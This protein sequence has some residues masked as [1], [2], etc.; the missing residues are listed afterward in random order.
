MKG[1]QGLIPLVIVLALAFGIS[2]TQ[3]ALG[4]GVFLA[5]AAE[6]SINV[7]FV[8]VIVFVLACIMAFSTGTSWGT[9][10]IM[11][12]I[13]I[14]MIATL[15]VHPPLMLAAALG[16]GIFGDHC[17]PIS[18]STIVASMAS[19]TDHI[20]HVRTQIPYALIAASIAIVLYVIF[21]FIL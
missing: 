5:Q 18:D 15:D 12:P 4:T 11:I 9:F 21:G 20:D 8:P 17:S 16:G 1:I 19:A 10:A 13:V 7:G 14:P 2:S 3:K 6:A